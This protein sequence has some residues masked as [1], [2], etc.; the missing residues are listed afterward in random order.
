M[1]TVVLRVEASI[2]F[3]SNHVAFGE[4]MGRMY[5]QEQVGFYSVD[6]VFKPF[7]FVPDEWLVT[8]GVVWWRG[9]SRGM[10]SI[11]LCTTDTMTQVLSLTIVPGK[12]EVLGHRVRLPSFRTLRKFIPFRDKKCHFVVIP[13]G[14]ET[15]VHDFRLQL[16]MAKYTG[17]RRQ[18][19]IED[20][21][22]VRNRL[23]RRDWSP[24]CSSE[25]VNDT[26]LKVARSPPI[27][28]V[29]SPTHRH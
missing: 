10:V 21:E 16:T 12:E 6:P 23:K 18:L 9:T 25:E 8:D 14:D 24:T 11:M 19:V 2:L 13:E 4:V 3:G 29:R 20:D 15:A 7:Y 26:L 5:Q 22:E 1:G 28:I 27:P 17:P